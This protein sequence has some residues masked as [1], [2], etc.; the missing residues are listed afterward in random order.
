MEAAYFVIPR[1][2]LLIFHTLLLTY[3]NLQINLYDY[4]LARSKPTVLMNYSSL[5]TYLFILMP[6]YTLDHLIH[7]HSGCINCCCLRNFVLYSTF[8]FFWG[9]GF[10]FIIPIIK[11]G[12]INGGF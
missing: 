8:L 5:L 4:F 11:L 2:W 6:S 10:I 1:I 7:S 9:G 3:D 12:N